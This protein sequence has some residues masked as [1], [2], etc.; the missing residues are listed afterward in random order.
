MNPRFDHEKLTVYQEALRF[1]A[2]ANK[3]LQ[4]VPKSWAVRDQLD[5]ASTS[6]PLNI[7]GRLRV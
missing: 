7:A 1:V 6:V 3:I 5:R 4:D 2:W